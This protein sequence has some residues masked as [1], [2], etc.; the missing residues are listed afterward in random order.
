MNDS[1]IWKKI[2][3][4]YGIVVKKNELV[5][6]NESYNEGKRT[7]PILC[8]WVENFRSEKKEKQAGLSRA[9]LKI[10]FWIFL[11]KVSNLG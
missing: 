1:Y 10:N 4:R 2:S 6:K 8:D 7:L 5:K 11:A 3:L 9:T